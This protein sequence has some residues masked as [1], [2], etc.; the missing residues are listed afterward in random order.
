MAHCR[1][2][3]AHLALT[4]WPTVSM[5][6]SLDKPSDCVDKPLDF[7]PTVVAALEALEFVVIAGGPVAF[8]ER[9]NA[10]R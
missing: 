3:V 4:L 8:R 5:P 2:R 10:Q 7:I 9:P 6:D 1:K